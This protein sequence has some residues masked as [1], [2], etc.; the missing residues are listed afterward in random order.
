MLLENDEIAEVFFECKKREN[1]REDFP[2]TNLLP[3]KKIDEIWEDGN[4]YIF[5]RNLKNYDG[6]K[7]YYVALPLIKI[8]KNI[9]EQNHLKN[10]LIN[11]FAYNNVKHSPAALYLRAGCKPVSHT[12]EEIQEILD[13]EEK[14]YDKSIIFMYKIK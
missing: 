2:D 4:N 9:V 14:G 1:I 5:I 12:E 3:D 6:N 13:S 11:A 7:Y 8:L 10:V